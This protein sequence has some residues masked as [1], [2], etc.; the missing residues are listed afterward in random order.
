M[1][2]AH[3]SI[4]TTQPSGGVVRSRRLRRIRHWLFW[5][6]A[7]LLLSFVFINVLAYRH[8][9]AFTHYSLTAASPPKPESL[10][11]S[12]KLS[13]AIRGVPVPRPRNTLT[14]MHVGLPYESLTIPH[15][16]ESLDAW[17]VDHAHAKGT[18]ILGPGYMMAK[19]GLMQ[20]LRGAN[21]IGFAVLAIDFRGA[22]GSPGNT[23]TLGVHEGHDYAVAI[24]YARSRWPRRPIVAYG[25]S[26]GAAAALKAIAAHDARVDG[27][28]L[29]APFDR[30]SQ[31]IANRLCVMNAP[32]WPATDLMLFWGSQ[33]LN[34]NAFSHNPMD[35]A[36]A[37]TAPTLVLHANLDPRATPEMVRNVVANL[38]KV[39]CETWTIRDH[40]PLA[41]VDRGRWQQQVNAWW[42]ANAP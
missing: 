25:F 17:F 27:L 19:D 32:S 35:D 9:H 26:M 11:F 37:V 38:R 22:G 13:I 29:D 12:H 24:A 18:M 21:A 7:M 1:S 15:S 8:V 40:T 31:T 39:M 41:R 33:Q 5:F 6:A 4:G 10:T 30:M 2:D 28:I 34:I 3:Q 16:D 42:N 20:E 36:L 14:P 23:V